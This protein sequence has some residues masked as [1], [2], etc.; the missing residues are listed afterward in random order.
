MDRN[1]GYRAYADMQYRIEDR[2]DLASRKKEIGNAKEFVKKRRE[3]RAAAQYAKLTVEEKTL[4]EELKS[5]LKRLRKSMGQMSLLLADP[6]KLV[7]DLV[8]PLNRI[9]ET[10]ETRYIQVFDQVN[11]ATEDARLSVKAMTESDLV[12]ALKALN[13]VSALEEAD[14]EALSDNAETL[15][16][17]LFP[18]DLRAS[19]V[20]LELKDTA[21][22]RETGDLIAEAQGWITKAQDAQESAKSLYRSQIVQRAIALR[23]Y[24]MHSLLEQ[25]KTDKFISNILSSQDE[26]ALADLLVKE[27][28]AD[29][30]KAKLLDKYLKKIRVV[31]VRLS[32]FH[33]GLM[34]FGQDD[35]DTVVESFRQFLGKRLSKGSDDETVVISIEK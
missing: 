18:S 15:L 32:D 22:P 9:R 13:Q 26:N 20:R 33:P 23:S 28:S 6:A 4:Q 11:A 17:H 35:L 5:H 8:E 31:R 10:Y 27:L 16:D 19:E 29:P 25:G 3:I 14:L 12:A 7:T 24:D 1:F 2:D 21:Y 30:K 34:T